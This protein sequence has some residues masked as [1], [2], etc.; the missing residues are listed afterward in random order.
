MERANF[1]PNYSIIINSGT[2][3]FINGT[4]QYGK[5]TSGELFENQLLRRLGVRYSIVPCGGV[6]MAFGVDFKDGRN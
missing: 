6:F 5:F 2:S 3:Y 4:T 1:N